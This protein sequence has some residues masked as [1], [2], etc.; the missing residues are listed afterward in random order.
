MAAIRPI[1]VQ[2]YP[3]EHRNTRTIPEDTNEKHKN[4]QVRD[5]LLHGAPSHQT[6]RYFFPKTDRRADVSFFSQLFAESLATV[7]NKE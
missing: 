1:S 2:R 3:I 6:I 7:G 4:V 5:A